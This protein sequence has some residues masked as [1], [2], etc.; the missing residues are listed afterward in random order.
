MSIILDV[1]GWRHLEL[2]HLVMDLNGT[3]ALDGTLVPGVKEAVT[4]LANSLSCHLITAD[5][6][7]TAKELFGDV[8]QLQVIS[9]G[10]ED[11]QKLELV[12]SL[13]WEH[14]AAMGNGANDVLMLERAVVG[15][16]LLGPEGASPQALA[17]A[18]VAVDHPV[19]ALELFL[20]TGRLKATLRR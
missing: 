12:D 7:G 8:V 10:N 17:A 9:P 1:P 14:V 15:V 2:H 5:T 6:F 4:Q 11:R 19:R 18:D 20:K 16:A 3:L 13:G